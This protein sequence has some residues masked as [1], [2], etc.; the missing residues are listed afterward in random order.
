M[1]NVIAPMQL[2]P[3]WW[4]VPLIMRGPSFLSLY[5]ALLTWPSWNVRFGYPASSEPLS[6]SPVQSTF[7]WYCATAG[8]PDRLPA[9]KGRVSFRLEPVPTNRS[10]ESTALWPR[11]PA[12]PQWGAEWAGRRREEKR[13]RKSSE[14]HVPEWSVVFL[15]PS[16]HKCTLSKTDCSVVGRRAPC[17]CW[18]HHRHHMLLFSCLAASSFVVWLRWHQAAPRA[19]SVSLLAVGWTLW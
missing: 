14:R 11:L 12:N 8:N 9:V 17:V 13:G 2:E 7:E 18:P 10:R 4:L 6:R 3:F 19:I 15:R 16:G 1:N 5:M